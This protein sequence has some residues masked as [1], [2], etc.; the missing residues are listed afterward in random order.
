MRSAPYVP[1]AREVCAMKPSC[2]T[3]NSEN[4]GLVPDVCQWAATE[5][6][7]GVPLCW[8]HASAV[9][10]GLRPLP[11]VVGKVGVR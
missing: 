7:G 4:R 3:T 6:I 5:V 9:K 2:W 11:V 1:P 8:V 10:A